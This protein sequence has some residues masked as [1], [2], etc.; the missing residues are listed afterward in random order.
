M[1]TKI[2]LWIMIAVFVI[3]IAFAPKEV[4]VSASQG[5]SIEYP[6]LY[7]LQQYEDV[8]F[9][10]HVYNATSGYPILNSSIACYFHLYDS[11]GKH[12]Y[13]KTYIK[14]MNNTYDFIIHIDGKN[15]SEINEYSYI[16]QC[17]DSDIGGWVRAPLDIT[18]S[19]RSVID[20]FGSLSIT[21]FFIVLISLLII[22]PLKIRLSSVEWLHVFLSRVS[23]LI[24][25]FLFS[26]FTAVV[27]DISFAAGMTTSG[28]LFTIL[29]C[30]QW[31]SYCGMLALFLSLL[32]TM[33]DMWK[34][35]KQNKRMGGGQE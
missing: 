2:L 25:L 34:I 10:F 21:L 4:I 11:I 8:Y 19:G 1:N 18:L 22:L 26:L 30:L 3:P 35:K 5:L 13:Y 7:N 29:W 33:L 12:I 17:N 23:W 14:N 31:G 28:A 6:A 32:F 20:A 9:N 15:F 16:F 24:A 27:T